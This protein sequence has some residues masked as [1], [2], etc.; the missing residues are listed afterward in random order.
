MI[1]NKFQ[2]GRDKMKKIIRKALMVSA[3]MAAGAVNVQA[4]EA[5]V[6]ATVNGEQILQSELDAMVSTLSGRMAQYG[7]DSS[8]ETVMET[9]QTA[10]LEE[11]V[12]DRLLTQDMTLQGCYEFTEEEESEILAAAQTSL[13]NLKIQCEAYFTEYLDG[14]EEGLTAAELAE[15]YMEE[16]GYN[17]EYLE[18]YGRNA[19][20]SEKYEDWLMEEEPEITEKQIQDTYKERVADSRE[21]Y[22]NDIEAFEMAISNGD[23][24][25]YRPGGYRAVL[26]IM[27]AAEGENEEEKL[28]SVEGTA[29]EIYQ[30]LEQGEPFETLIRE[31]GEDSAFDED[32]FL[33]T[34]YQVHKD[35][36]IWEDAFVEAAFGEQMKEPGDYTEPLVFGDSVHILYYLKDVP[37]GEAELTEELSEALRQELYEER[38]EVRLEERLEELTGEA[39]IAYPE[40]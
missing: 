26:Q 30:R 37:A 7:I 3:V 22:E 15:S 14:Q 25:W 27:L 23:E 28:A 10:A 5:V 13:E 38:A 1:L 20:A 8:D 35:S 17:L 12:D 4:E 34:G 39:S 6:A 40:E 29:N 18:N 19:L 11:L 2:K 32:S 16:K 9:I 36:V 33:E 31:Y 24:V 21:A